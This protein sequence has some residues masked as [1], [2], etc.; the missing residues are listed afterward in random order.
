M[1]I[2][3]PKRRVRVTA[4]VRSNGGVCLMRCS[5]SIYMEWCLLFTGEYEPEVTQ[6]IRGALSLGGTFLDVGANFGIHAVAAAKSGARVIACEPHPRAME[7]LRANAA[8]NSVNDL[9]L[10]RV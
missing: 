7:R 10:M 4:L 5:S 8:L 2:H 1:A 3:P 9:R 6:L